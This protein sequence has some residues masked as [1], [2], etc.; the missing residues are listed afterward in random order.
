MDCSRRDFS[1]RQFLAV[2]GGASLIPA[3]AAQA[4]DITLRIAETTLEIGPK[5]SVRT[6]A[7]NGQCPGPLLRMT[8]GKPVTVEAVNET[9]APEMI[10][11]H[12]F[13]IPP[14]VDGAHEEGTP[15]IQGL[16]RRSYTFTPRPA[17]TRWYH[18]HAL[19]G[20]NLNIGLYSGQFGMVIVEPKEN[21]ARYDME[22]PIVLHEWEPFFASGP[23]ASGHAMDVNFRYQS[24]NGRMLGF[25]EPVRVKQGQ[26]ALFRVLNASATNTHKLA[27]AGH[28]FNVIA[29]DGNA[30]SKPQ[31]VAVL[32]VA[33]G[34]RVDAI[35][36]LSNPGVWIL[37]ET[38]AA[39]RAAGAGIA[40]EYAGMK[41]PAKWL[42]PPASEWD[43]TIFGEATEAAPAEVTAPIVI[44]PGTGGNLWAV[45]GKSW[46]DTDDIYLRPG[47]RNRLIFDNRGDMDHPFHLHRHTFE[48]V[49]VAG[50]P[51]AGVSKDVVNVPAR[52]VVEVDVMAGSPGPSLFHCHQQFHMDFGFMAMLKYRNG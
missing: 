33:P 8:E 12:G 32:A 14:E 45:N 46:P 10:H 38:D 43:Y 35:V 31:K 1:R 37:G 30:V 9:R 49:R 6:L 40:I 29:L 18:T 22:V 27:F 47:I 52:K 39:S 13:H 15:M 36:E 41:G 3:R 4:P 7:Y 44:T 17:G 24:I 20:H 26:R 23:D 16:S 25:G 34:E 50:K 48:L 5:R 19:A 42:A 51:V 2:A 21:P 11:W 28:Q